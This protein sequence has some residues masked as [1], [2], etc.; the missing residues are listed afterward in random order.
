MFI[1]FRCVQKATIRPRRPLNRTILQTRYVRM[2]KVCVAQDHVHHS[3][4]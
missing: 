2:T 1:I 3:K 4:K